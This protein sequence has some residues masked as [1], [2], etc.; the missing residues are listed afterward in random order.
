MDSLRGSTPDALLDSLAKEDTKRR[1]SWAVRDRALVLTALLTGMRLGELVRADIG[2]IRTV[3]TGGAV[4][5]GRGKG[6]RDRRKPIEAVLLAVI[7]QYLSSRAIRFPSSGRGS[8]PTGESSSWP[9][10]AALFVD[11]RSPVRITRDTVQYR[12]LRAFAR[13]GVESDRQ[14]GALVHALRHTFATDLANA[15]VAVYELKNLLGHESLAT[16]QRYV[17]GAGQETRAA[18]ARNPLYERLRDG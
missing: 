6:G 8:S 13:A 9:A 10:N 1:D 14:R 15:N 18:A 11:A 16:S 17:D 7:E 2:D 12:V 3:H 5:H 4:I